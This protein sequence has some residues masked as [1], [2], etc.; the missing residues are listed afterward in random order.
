MVGFAAAGAGALGGA[1]LRTTMVIGARLG[2]IR[3]FGTEDVLEIIS[4]NF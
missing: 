1:A 4:V 3:Q 2:A